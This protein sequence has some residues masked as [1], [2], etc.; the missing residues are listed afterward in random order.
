M[1]AV[2]CHWREDYLVQ[3]SQLQALGPI[4]HWLP[5]QIWLHFR[6]GEGQIGDLALLPVLLALHTLQKPSKYTS[7]LLR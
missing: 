2:G 7:V 5:A 6:L 3:V 1:R 4:F